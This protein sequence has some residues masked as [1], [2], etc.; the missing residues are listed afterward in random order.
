MAEEKLDL[1]QGEGVLP[2]TR[3]SE[4][5]SIGLKQSSGIV[6]EEFKRELRFPQSIKTYKQM[7]YDAVIQSGL[8]TI[9]MM[10]T[11]AK[12][13]VVAPNEPTE[14]ELQKARFIEQCMGDME[15][16]WLSFMKEVASYRTY[17]FC[18]NEKVFRK[19]L[20]RKGS[21]Y[22]DGL[23]GWKKLPVR[24]QDTITK[25]NYSSDGRD[26]ISVTQDMSLIADGVLPRSLQG[27]IEIPRDKF[28]LFTADAKR[29]NPTGNS[30][31]NKVWSAWKYRTSFQELEAVSMS[32]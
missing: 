3:L 13:R 4:I 10:L 14:E 16:S 15:H 29:G 22:N 6:Y 30:P 26:F 27:E 28:L 7:S 1:A 25:F 19:R 5:G 21:R 32:R 31:L 17:G 2:R 9:E 12:W 24:S 8:Q 20:K 11:R 23:I 18:I